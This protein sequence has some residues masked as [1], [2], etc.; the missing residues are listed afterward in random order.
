MGKARR[1]GR[2][3]TGST[4]LNYVRP[5]STT[6]APCRPVV[7][8]PVA[9]SSCEAE[10]LVNKQSGLTLPPE[11]NMAMCFKF[12]TQMDLGCAV[13]HQRKPVRTFGCT[14]QVPVAK[15]FEILAKCELRCAYNF[16]GF[17]VQLK[18]VSGDT[19]SEILNRVSSHITK[20]YKKVHV[21]K[22]PKDVIAAMT[23]DLRGLDVDVTISGKDM[24]LFKCSDGDLKITCNQVILGH[25]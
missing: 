19:T 8:V 5:P 2:V 21:A 6:D 20:L 24:V 3:T 13:C 16:R 1:V 4:T 25:S 15:A 17:A 9:C 22:R 11:C 12:W 10:A 7:D 14:E 23:E 18:S